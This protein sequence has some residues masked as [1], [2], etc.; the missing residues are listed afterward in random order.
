METSKFSANSKADKISAALRITLGSIFLW[1]FL[2]K[3][4]GLGFSTCRDAATGVVDIVCGD[5]WING[6]SPTSGFLTHGT[7][8][9]FGSLFQSMSG[10]ILVDGLFMFGL[11]GLGIALI[12]GIGMRIA[13]YAGSLLL[14]LIWAAGLP[15]ENH[16]FVDEH[17]IYILSLFGLLAVND[18]QAFG[19]GKWWANTNPAKKYPILK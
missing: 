8:G 7:G 16:P 13:A 6:G 14:L 1:A 5:A 18:S 10:S 4:F 2:D 15:T 11:A 9:P 3:L 12:L 17:I 19:L